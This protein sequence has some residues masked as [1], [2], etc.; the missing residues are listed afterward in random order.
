MCVIAI[1][2]KGIPLPSET[3]F[4]NCWDNNRDGAGFMWADGNVVHIEKG[5][6]KYQDFKQAVENLKDKLGEDLTEIPM[7]FHFRI[8]TAGGNIPANCHPF[9]LTNKINV[10]QKLETTTSVGIAH[11]G[12]IHID[13]RSKDISDT[14]E[15]IAAQLW[16]LSRVCKDWYLNDHC[17]QIIESSTGSKLAFM[18]ADGSI[19]TVGHFIEDKDGMLY[20]NS[21]YS[22]RWGS[23]RYYYH[24]GS[25]LN[26][27]TNLGEYE[28]THD[29]CYGDPDD[30]SLP[31]NSGNTRRYSTERLMMVPDG[32]LIEIM[33]TNEL[34]EAGTDLLCYAINDKLELFI[35]DT[36]EDVAYPVINDTYVYDKQGAVLK[37]EY[38]GSEFILVDDDGLIDMAEA[39][40]FDVDDVYPYGSYNAT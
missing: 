23:S 3:A 5:F 18:L 10:M 27:I 22:Y 19:F 40:S 6:M 12:I 7:V 15:W 36:T 25:G 38:E 30:W 14:M 35:Y 21:S 31:S 39:D 32:S 37:F 29:L 11:N 1:K 17:M 28:A 26:N 34:I 16:P 9:P 2:N 13:T 20:S 33:D 24:S 8:G 4:Q